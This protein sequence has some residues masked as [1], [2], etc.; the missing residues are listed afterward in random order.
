MEILGSQLKYYNTMNTY[1]VSIIGDSG[2]GKSTFIHRYKQDT[3]IQE[4]MPTIGVEVHPC[5]VHTTNG[6]ICFNMWDI[7]G[8]EKL[9]GLLDGYLVGSNAII[10]MFSYDSKLSYTSSKRLYQHVKKSYPNVPVLLI[11]NKIDIVPRKVCVVDPLF[12]PVRTVDINVKN[13]IGLDSV[14]QALID[15]IIDDPTILI[16]RLPI[17][18]SERRRELTI[19]L[20]ELILELESLD[21]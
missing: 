4:Y 10:V 1:K 3:F 16:T 2:V 5:I 6:P 11:G 9:R 20:K 21:E 12:T 17:D 18:K 15:I 13:E 8:Q 7:S 19:Q 14:F